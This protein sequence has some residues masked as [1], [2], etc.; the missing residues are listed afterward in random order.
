MANP[1]IGMQVTKKL[2]QQ[3]L[4]HWNAPPAAGI[5]VSWASPATFAFITFDFHHKHC[6]TVKYLIVVGDYGYSHNCGHDTSKG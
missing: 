4:D 6:E 2:P 3:Q 5:R 1:S